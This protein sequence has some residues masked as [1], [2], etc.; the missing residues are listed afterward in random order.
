MFS[1]DIIFVL[2]HLQKL[3]GDKKTALFL[4]PDSNLHVYP[5]NSS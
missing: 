2:V 5:D 1:M 3:W 4:V